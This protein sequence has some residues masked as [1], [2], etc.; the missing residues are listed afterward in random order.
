MLTSGARIES[1]CA[2]AGTGKSFTVGA[3]ADTWQGTG[4]RVFGLATSQAA[5]DVLAEANVTA[6]NI[7]SWLA[8]QERLDE[9]DPGGPDPGGDGQWRLQP[10]DLVVVDEAG[11]ADTP[12]LATI[13]SRCE[14]AGAKLLLTGDP[15]QLAAV[16]AG[17]AFADLAAHG[18]RYEL[19]EVRRFTTAWERSASLALRDGDPA[20]LD[21]YQRHGRLLDG[22][23]VEQAEAS[24]A[25]AWLADTLAGRE[26]L[27][28]V[29]SNAAA[30]RVSSA[31]RADLIALGRV[32]ETGVELGKDGTVAGVGDL[33]QARRNGWDLIGYDGNAAAPINRATYRVTGL[34]A[35]GG[36]TVA[37]LLTRD[38]GREP[39]GAPM[40]L[41]AS[42]VAADVTLG[43]ASTVHAA[44]GRTVDT[45]HA[46]IAHGQDAGTAYVAL[47]RGRDRNTAHVVTRAVPD[48]AE[49]GQTHEVAERSPR[50]VLAEVIERDPGE[51]EQSALVVRERAEQQARSTMTHVDKLTY[52][53]DRIT[54]GRTGGQL[55]RLAAD[56]VLSDLDRRRLAAA[57]RRRRRRDRGR[58]GDA[59]RRAARRR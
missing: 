34:R 52:H 51:T 44:Q 38:N 59:A 29:S 6:R 46:V 39:L 55:D 58:A 32:T 30:A 36:L 13:Q 45:A 14:Q 50:A 11:M 26:S 33:V 22:G 41:P 2:A 47:T 17:G 9:A 3:I 15:R 40:Q 56:G 21:A 35:D 5:T 57:R 19:A 43:Y 28:L 48:D 1:V 20:A 4:Y 54:A 7:P 53:V 37:P 18:V 16:G 8:A 23:T 12:H 31:L 25:R 27:L 24:A 42:Y 10:G 49:P